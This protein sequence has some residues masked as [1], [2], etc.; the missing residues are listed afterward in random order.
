MREIKD[1]FKPP[2]K[3]GGNNAIYDSEKKITGDI[4]FC[5]FLNGYGDIKS[6][7]EERRMQYEYMEF[8]AAA[9]NE[10]WER[11][12]GEPSRWELDNEYGYRGVRCPKCVTEYEVFL[13]DIE[14]WKYCPHCGQKLLSPEDDK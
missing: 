10:K 1:L 2:F 4:L 11:D 8:I 14:D 12:F 6:T 13:E 9:L 7:Q 3:W 5:S